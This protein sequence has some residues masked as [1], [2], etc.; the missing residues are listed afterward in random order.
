MGLN[1]LASTLSLGSPLVCLDL[2]TT[3]TNRT[4]DRIVQIG[5]VRIA[6]DG[7]VKEWQ[8]LVNPEMHIP[9][10]STKI[11]H[12][13]DEMVK[14]APTF[15]HLAARLARALHMCDFCGYNLPF[16]LN[17][18]ESEFTRVRVPCTLEGRIVDGQRIFH[19]RERRNLIAAVKL[20]LP[21]LLLRTTDPE[22]R[23]TIEKILAEADS[24]AHE[25]L[26]DARASAWVVK[27]QLE[28]YA[29]LPRTVE[30]LHTMFFE[31]PQRE[32]HVDADGKFAWRNGEAVVNFGTTYMGV[33][34]A[35]VN[36]K[37]F[38]WILSNDFT[39]RVK[40]IAK[41]ALNGKFLRRT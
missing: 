13:T 3:G 16:D 26:W 35:N 22:D 19:R 9:E 41:D 37:F 36:P 11:H 4:F 33:P 14:D 5:V 31:T 20:Y 21:F 25:A 24:A 28:Y 39:P 8:T 32:D 18:L 23:A 12:I 34:L 40:Q 17:M 38:R 2:E 1:E 29:D 27:A 7:E 6:P 30:S 10:E 15:W